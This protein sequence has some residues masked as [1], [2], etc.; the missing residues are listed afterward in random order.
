MRDLIEAARAGLRY[1][2]IEQRV[3]AIAGAETIV[4]TTRAVLLWEPRRICPIYAVPADDIRADLEPAEANHEQ[5]PGV[6]HPGIPFIVHTAAGEPVT[7]A[8][9]AGFR[10]SEPGLDGYVSL[11]FD[12]F[13]WLGFEAK[14][15]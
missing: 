10:L 1:E 12:A 13:D 7:V 14:Q 15:D 5:V 6:L 9:H 11:D 8:G 2:P 4:D 3:R